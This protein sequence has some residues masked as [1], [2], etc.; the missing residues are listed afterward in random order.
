MSLPVADA[1]A[2]T[3]RRIEFLLQQVSGAL[4]T[5]NAARDAVV[6]VPSC[7]VFCFDTDVNGSWQCVCVNVRV[8]EELD[9]QR[10]SDA[11]RCKRVLCESL[12]RSLSSFLS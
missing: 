2:T 4:H 9:L 10:C 6:Q 3:R 8:A 1:S 12:P 5:L 11:A 7:S